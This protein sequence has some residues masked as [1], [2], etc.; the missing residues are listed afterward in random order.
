LP[1]FVLLFGNEGVSQVKFPQ[2]NPNIIL[3]IG[4]ILADPENPFLED[5]RALYEALNRLERNAPF[6]RLSKKYRR[7]AQTL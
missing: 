4:R 1:G 3:K 5:A 2:T 7:R 6:Q